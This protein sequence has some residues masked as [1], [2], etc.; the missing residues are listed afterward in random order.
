MGN[1]VDR[2]SERWGAAPDD[3]MNWVTI[4]AV[5]A[6]AAALVHRNATDHSV[7]WTSPYRAVPGTSPSAFIS[8]LD[9]VHPPS[10]P[11]QRMLSLCCGHGHAERA[12]ANSRTVHSCDGFDVS[13]LALDHA[14]VLARQSG[15]TQFRYY[16]HDI[17]AV[18]L[19]GVYDFVYAAGIHHIEQLEHAFREVRAHLAPGAPFMMYEYIGLARCQYTPRQLEAINACIRLLPERLRVR[20]TAQRELG[21]RSAADAYDALQRRRASLDCARR[22]DTAVFALES[23]G[24]SEYVEPRPYGV[25]IC[26]PSEQWSYAAVFPRLATPYGLDQCMIVIDAQVQGGAI[27]IGCVAVD[28]ATYVTEELHLQGS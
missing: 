23:A 6:R 11:I 22:I 5:E 3:A 26:T 16:V 27:G 24:T 25:R 14:A 2:V 7:P 15:F 19:E 10:R 28:N 8:V 4:P 18:R 20:V 13:A 12:F 1:A 9:S 21:A 17:N